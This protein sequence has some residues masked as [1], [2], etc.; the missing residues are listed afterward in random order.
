MDENCK[1]IYGVDHA[2]VEFIYSREEADKRILEFG[3]AVFNFC[4]NCGEC[5]RKFKGG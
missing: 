2:R 4:P 1:H 3:V 5:I